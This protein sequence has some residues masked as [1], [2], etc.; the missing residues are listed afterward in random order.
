MKTAS[1]YTAWDLPHLTPKSFAELPKRDQLL[2]LVALAHLAPSSHNTQPWRFFVDEKN[3]T[4]NLYI[5]RIR[6]LPASDKVG[7]QTLIGVG[8]ALENLVV[9]AEYFGL[10]SKITL[11][12]NH[13]TKILPWENNKNLPRY[14]HV[15]SINFKP[16]SPNLAYETLVK[17]I[18]ERKVVRAEYDPERKISEEIIKE[19]EKIP[20][21]EITRLHLITDNLRRLSIS[22]FQGQADGFVINSKTFSR[23]LG[24]WL[25]PNDTE[26]PVGMPGNNFGLPDDQ[27]RRMHQG[28]LGETPLEPEDG[29]RFA[30]AGKMGIE[31]S[32]LIGFITVKK[33]TPENWLAAGRTFEKIFL[34]L[35]TNGIQVAVHAGIVEVPL[36]KQI[37]SMTLGTL[38]PIT[39][40]FRAGYVK[41]EEDKARPHSPRLPLN[42]VILNEADLN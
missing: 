23:E 30:I 8:A 40:L 2:H 36:I 9:A 33:D 4:I 5:D 28:L 19:L 3:N 15:A 17:S 37:F 22:E 32:P 20:D 13:E 10:H 42:E 7:R 18:T 31:K 29:L 41:K 14:T 34:T 26:S 1:N 25:L 27:A 12:I 24:E 21:G 11:H 6:V 35:V 16:S 38:R 39:A